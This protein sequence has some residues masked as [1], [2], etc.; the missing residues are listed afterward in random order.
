MRLRK[1]NGPGNRAAL[2]VP[3]F[4]GVGD[5]MKIRQRQV[6]LFAQAVTDEFVDEMVRHVSE[7]APR[8]AVLLGEPAVREIIRMGLDRAEAYGLT[9]RGPVRLY[10]DLMFLFGCG[11]DTDPQ[12]PWAARNLRSRIIPDQTTRASILHTEAMSYIH[13]VLGDDREHVRAAMMRIRTHLE[14][15]APVHAAREDDAL[16][17]LRF[18]YPTKFDHAGEP[19][20]RALIRNSIDLAKVHDV[21]SGEG[22]ALFVGLAFVLGHGFASDPLF[23]WIQATLRDP[24]FTTPARRTEGLLRMTRAYLREAMR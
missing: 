20:M 16:D 8:M 6:A 22:N 11:F 24:R 1:P 19:V 21:A 13:H 17:R 2:R 10:L 23:P 15:L 3:T 14:D 5:V 18:L 9:N 7:F 12:L 4:V